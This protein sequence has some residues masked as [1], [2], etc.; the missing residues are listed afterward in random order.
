MKRDKP[1]MGSKCERQ[2]RYDVKKIIKEINIS[3]MLCK[4]NW[5][6]YTIEVVEVEQQ[7]IWACDSIV[8][9]ASFFIIHI[10]FNKKLWGKGLKGRYVLK[11][12]EEF[13][14]SIFQF[15][16][17]VSKIISNI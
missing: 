2:E 17:C 15:K 6:N 11:Q 13:D 14:S 8:K 12:H 16:K 10:Y 5:D 7:V 4:N 1:K 3:D 9:L